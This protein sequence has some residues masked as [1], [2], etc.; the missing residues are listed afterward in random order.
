MFGA[1]LYKK[2]P[3]KCDY[4]WILYYESYIKFATQTLFDMWFNIAI[5]VTFKISFL[6]ILFT[7]CVYFTSL[8]FKHLFL[9]TFKCQIQFSFSYFSRSCSYETGALPSLL[10]ARLLHCYFLVNMFVQTVHF[11]NLLAS[12]LHAHYVLAF[13]QIWPLYLL[14]SILFLTSVPLTVEQAV[15]F[16][17]HT[18]PS[19]TLCASSSNFFRW[20]FTDFL[21][22]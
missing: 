17:G 2:I 3:W 22:S 21:L 4:Q 14:S 5:F 13:F 9:L 16:F 11:C 19:S 1:K 20:L 6:L 8:I 10:H 7:L 15:R 12:D 18:N